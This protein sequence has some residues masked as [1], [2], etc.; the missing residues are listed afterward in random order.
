MGARNLGRTL[1]ILGVLAVVLST[2]WWAYHYN[3]V[4]QSLGPKPSFAHPMRCLLWTA[5]VCTQAQ[6]AGMPKTPPRVPP[7]NPLAL[8]GSLVVLLIGLV[9]VNRSTSTQPYPVTP[10]GEPRLFIPKLEPFYAWVRDLSWPL[11][12]IAAG[13]TLLAIGIDK[14]LNRDINVFA[15]GSMARRGLEPAM[16]L[17]YFI[18][19]LESFGALMIILGLFTRFFGAAL[20]IQFFVITFVAQFQTG[21]LPARGWGIFVMWGLIFFAV[22]LRGGG[23]YSLDRALG[24]EL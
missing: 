17:A 14:V 9:V 21:F 13:G 12:R 18:Y 19:F 11:V 8:W 3:G 1:V 16:P 2:G 24:R 15:T 10:P 6:A 20:A 5:D 4:I 23:P 7:Y 22:A